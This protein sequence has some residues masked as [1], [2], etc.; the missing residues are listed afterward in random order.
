MEKS[1]YKIQFADVRLTPE[2]LKAT[3]DKIEQLEMSLEKHEFIVKRVEL[4]FQK[5]HD[6][7]DFKMENLSNILN[8]DKDYQILISNSFASDKISFHIRHMP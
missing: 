1:K 6:F 2:Q 8:S 7:T 5:L 4:F 3:E